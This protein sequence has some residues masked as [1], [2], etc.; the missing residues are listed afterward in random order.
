MVIDGLQRL[1]AISEFLTNQLTRENIIKLKGEIN[2]ESIANMRRVLHTSFIIHI[3]E[4][5]TQ[6]TGFNIFHRINNSQPKPS[7]IT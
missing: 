6:N 1:I 4:E 5:D 2:G 3:L 7:L